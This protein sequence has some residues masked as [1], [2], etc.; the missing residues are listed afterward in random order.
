MITPTPGRVVWFHTN[1]TSAQPDPK[2]PLAALIT[3]V[4]SDTLVNLSVFDQ[5]G[6]PFSKTSVPLVQD[7][8][9]SLA[10]FYAEWMPYQTGQA[11]K[12]E[13]LQAELDAKS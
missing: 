7:E 3:Y 8:A 12:T 13:K 11:A 6:L 4:H 9:G 2:Q 5:N 1:D 10:S